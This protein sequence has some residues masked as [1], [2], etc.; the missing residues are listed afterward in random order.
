MKGTVNDR[1]QYF[2]A[3]FKVFKS[4]WDIILNLFQLALR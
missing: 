2:H 1:E 3:K 4:F